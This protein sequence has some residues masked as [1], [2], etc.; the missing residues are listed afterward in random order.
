MNQPA[1]NDRRGFTLVELLV[2]IAIIG[3]LVGL[4]LPAVQSAREAA[5]RTSCTNNLKQWG[6]AMHNH[7]DANGYLPF[8]TNRL[9]PPGSEATTP[10]TNTAAD[11]NVA[12]GAR[13]TFI[14]SLWPYLEQADLFLRWRATTG[15]WQAP[16]L[17]LT[18]VAATHYYCPSD[19]PRAKYLGDSGSFPACRVNYVLNFGPTTAFDSAN[20]RK[21]PF[22]FLSGANFGTFVPYRTKLA[23]VT[24]GTSKTLLM[25]ECRLSNDTSTDIRGHGFDDNGGPYF[26]ARNPPNSGIDQAHRCVSASD[27]PPCSTSTQANN[28]LMARSQHPGGVTVAMGDNAVRFIANTIDPAAWQALSTM[29]GGEGGVDAD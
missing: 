23:E 9:N 27:N 14:I 10:L 15:F 19:R 13:R 5:R 1:S 24:D 18:G 25:A 3:T 2:V 6:L 7:H 22:G 16:N 12:P 11:Y 28:S 29:N 17:A 21:A 26:M 4:L 8:G 20:R